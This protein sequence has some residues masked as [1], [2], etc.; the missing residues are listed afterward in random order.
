M[1]RKT[2]ILTLFAIVL[3]VINCLAQEV[4]TLTITATNFENEK[5]QAVVNLF[6]EQDDV[7]KKPFKT[8]KA[9]IKGGVGKL[10]V[11]NLPNG[12]TL[13]L[14]IMTKTTTAH[15]ITSLAFEINRWDSRM[16]GT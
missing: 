4:S 9:S 16:A 3:F 8:I 5:C 1:N 6:R 13:P 15:L 12:Y 11:E 14:S 10:V 2:S 7:P